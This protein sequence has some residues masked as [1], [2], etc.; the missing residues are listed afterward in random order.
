VKPA[1]SLC[2]ACEEKGTAD[3]GKTT[4]YTECDSFIG[5][6]VEASVL[7]RMDPT[8]TDVPDPS[9]CGP[10]RHPCRCSMCSGTSPYC[11]AELRFEDVVSDGKI[12]FLFFLNQVIGVIGP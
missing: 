8:D 3:D 5:N 2:I 11:D 9:V 12:V 4:T 10:A 6:G 7:K 1:D